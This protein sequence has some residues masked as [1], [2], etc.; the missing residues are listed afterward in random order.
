MGAGGGQHD[1]DGGSLLLTTAEQ[2][3]LS[4]DPPDRRCHSASFLFARRPPCAN[5][6][7]DRFE[8][9]KRQNVPL[10]RLSSHPLLP[11]L[12]LPPSSL[13]PWVFG[14]IS[15]PR[16]ASGFCIFCLQ[17]PSRSIYPSVCLSPWQSVWLFF[18]LST[19]VTL[20]VYLSLC[21][22]VYLSIYQSLFQKCLCFGHMTVSHSGSVD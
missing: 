11:A 15:A 18:C 14:T 19:S 10:C 17:S 16:F 1:A 12:V 6:A 8:K 13:H 7:L 21:L 22:S 5:L 4:H 9:H 3:W 20:H 2:L